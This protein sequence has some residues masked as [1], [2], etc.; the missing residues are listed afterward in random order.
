MFFFESMLAAII[1]QAAQPTPPSGLT[2]RANPPVVCHDARQPYLNFDFV[3]VNNGPGDVKLEELRAFVLDDNGNI[4]ERRFIASAPWL[5]TISAGADRLLYNPLFFSSAKAGSRI[6]YELDYDREGL[7]TKVVEVQPQHCTP[8]TSLVMPVTGRVLVYDGSDFHSHHRRSS[9]L[10]LEE[11]GIID[12]FQRFALDFVHVNA[13]GEPFEENRRLNS[14]W[15]AWD[16][17]VRAAGDGVVAATYN[18]Q[19]DNDVVGDENLWKQRS[20]A[21]NPMTTYGNYVLIDHGNGEFSLAAHLRHGS[22]TV[23]AGQTVK[24]GQVIGR[25][26]NSGSSLGPH[27][28]FE[29]RNGWGVNGIRTTPPR[30]GDV[31][32]VGTGEVAA[33]E[34]IAVNTG[35]V[36]LAH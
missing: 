16:Q 8:Q 2:F 13:A 19:P 9:Y 11:L 25:V 26:G 23:K 1:L 18:E 5:N 12:N 27:L 4:V 30:F 6:R 32:V 17:P 20:L 7:K 21:E 14:S 10:G 3:L 33:T 35:D 28:H 34:G 15:F 36:L 31:T 29:L 22:V 24:V